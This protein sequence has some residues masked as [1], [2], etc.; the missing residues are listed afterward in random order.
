MGTNVQR[1]PRVLFLDPAGNLWGS[2]QSLLLL[3]EGVRAECAEVALCT[4]RRGGL[5]ETARS[6]GIPTVAYPRWPQRPSFPGNHLA[7]ITGLIRAFRR[8]RPDILHLNQAGAARYATVAA[9]LFR[10]PIVVHC[11]LFEDVPLAVSRLQAISCLHFIAISRCVAETLIEAGVPPTR[12]TQITDPIRL[13]AIETK[14]ASSPASDRPSTVGFVGRL[15]ADK[16]V[17]F[18]IEAMAEVARKFP[19]ARFQLAGAPPGGPVG[20]AYGRHL[21]E[22]VKTLGLEAH[23][24]FLG[25]QKEVKRVMRGFDVLVTPSQR[26]PWGRVT[27]EALALSIPVV[28]FRSGG[29]E[30]IVEDGISG[31]LTKPESSSDLARGVAQLLSDPTQASRMGA[32]GRSWVEHH[33]DIQRHARSVSAVYSDLL[34]T[35]P[36]S[37]AM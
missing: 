20:E 23:C 37:P 13:P 33:C 14:P 30:E 28:A 22:L 8:F 10:C 4:P 17:E 21:K 19:S 9:K 16:G 32:A 35:S 5:V 26:E 36:H 11:R 15:S 1:R 6:A 12:W 29:S 18:F 7:A 24:E 34:A 31:F 25:F 2:E 27:A 3:M